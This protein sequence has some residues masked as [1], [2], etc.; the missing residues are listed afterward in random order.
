MLRAFI[1]DDEPLARDELAYLLNRCKIVEIAGEADNIDDAFEQLPYMEADVVFLDIQL[2]EESGIALA[3]RIQSM[4]DRPE[5]VFAT[6]FD[7]YALKAFELNAFDYILKP[8]DENRVHQTIIKLQKLVDSK[9]AVVNVDERAVKKEVPPI[10]KLA[11]NLDDRIALVNV[12][13]ILYI[14]S[15]EGK[16]IITTSS[17]KYE[18]TES[19]VAFER[20]LTNTSLIRVHRA[21]LVNFDQVIELQP[22][23]HSTYNLIMPDGASVP[24]SRTYTKE[25]KKR[26]GL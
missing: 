7:E 18:S 1:V 17:M 14:S 10:E 9:K 21:Y 25:L 24:V 8:F 4:I 3:E 13:D 22:W 26:V 5:I 2:A 15:E 20:K 6:A 12:K 19:L 23:F 11:I 16:T